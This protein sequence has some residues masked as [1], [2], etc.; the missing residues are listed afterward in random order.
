M[1]H[2]LVSP[3]SRRQF[4]QT[5]SSAAA[6]AILAPGYLR[7]EP[8]RTSCRPNILYI[9]V[10]DLGRA[11]SPYGAPVETPNLQ[12]FAN[13]GATLTQAFCSS[14]ACS[15]SRGCAM[16]GLHAHKTGLMGVNDEGNPDFWQL[17]PTQRTIVHDLNAAGYQTVHC[18]FQH[19]RHG[20]DA[21]RHSGY[22]VIAKKRRGWPDTFIENA[23]DD[24][25]S[26]LRTRQAGDD[27]RPFYM[28]V[29]AMEAHM[30]VISGQLATDYNRK[31]VY[32]VDSEAEVSVPEDFPD[33]RFSR[34]VL[35]QFWPCVRHLDREFGRL[36]QGLESL[37]LSDNTI[38]VFTTDHGAIGPRHKGTLYDGGTEIATLIRF[39]GHIAAG[40]HCD[41]LIGN[42]DFCP[43]LLEAAG[44]G[45][46][47]DLDGRSFWS[48]LIGSAEKKD[49]PIL[50]ELNYHLTYDPVRA[51]RTNNFL[52]LHNF[53]PQAR[54]L[55]SAPEILQL[56]PP[57]RNQWPNSSVMSAESFSM[58]KLSAWPLRAREEL[59]DLR[60]DPLQFRNL[61]S[62]PAFSE[63]LTAFRAA[64]LNWM[65]K[66]EDL[67]AQGVV[68]HGT[69]SLG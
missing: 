46:P 28:N 8:S 36:M 32:G 19:E 57:K 31:E 51:W 39:P 10:H 2:A 55:Y 45:I 23:V 16:T 7:S 4:M 42:V 29:G 65:Q 11:I 60:T 62:N 43:T 15:P 58:P 49:D 53:H 5:V 9:V 68:S 61:A 27:D 17:A 59:Y 3:L 47:P 66:N 34:E 33:N 52:Y 14:P 1:L 22:Q 37:G 54:H 6:G 41:S 64:V 12:A 24:A 63:Q 13:S 26:W 30:A 18:G 48:S 67:L 38:V 20:K 69:G 56:P 25:L 21:D 35:S 50:M 44:V 40:S